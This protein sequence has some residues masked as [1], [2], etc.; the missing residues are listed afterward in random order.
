MDERGGL[1]GDALLAGV[2]AVAGRRGGG[3]FAAAD[4]TGAAVEAF[5]DAL[6]GEVVEIAPHRRL[7][8]AERDGKVRHPHEIG[9]L[10]RVEH[11]RPS[12]H[13]GSTKSRH[14]APQ[15]L[16]ARQPSPRRHKHCIKRQ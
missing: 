16:S 13:G 8:N 12:R 6:G 4:E 11:P 1:P 10:Q 7:G 2:E 5:D 9:L 3:R 15:G 14:R